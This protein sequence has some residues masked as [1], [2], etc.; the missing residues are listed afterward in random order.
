VERLLAT[1]TS[2]AAR[3][4]RVLQF[5]YRAHVTRAQQQPGYQAVLKAAGYLLSPAALF[6]TSSGPDDPEAIELAFEH[7]RIRG[8]HA[9]RVPP[10]SG[11]A[12]RR[13]ER[14]YEYSSLR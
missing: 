6:V 14:A 9:L 5:G 13:P 4:A 10:A 11:V 3:L 2:P 1:N 7:L 8:V 12:V